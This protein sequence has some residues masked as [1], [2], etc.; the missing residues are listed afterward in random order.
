MTH[1]HGLNWRTRARSR[2]EQAGF[3][4]AE[5]VIA[6]AIS[7]ICLGGVMV[8]NAQQLKL[9]RNTRQAN[10][11]SMALEDRVEQLRL[12]AWANLTDTAW[13]ENHVFDKLPDCAQF[14]PNYTEIVTLTP[15]GETSDARMEVVNKADGGFSVVS[16]GATMAKQRQG[17][18]DVV[19]RW[20]G[21]DKRMRERSYAT[22]ISNGGITRVGL[23][24]SGGS[25]TGSVPG[26]ATS[27]I[28]L[29]PTDN[30]A[31][32]AGAAPSGP[33][34]TP[35]PSPTLTPTEPARAPL[36]PEKKSIEKPGRGNAGGKGGVG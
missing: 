29:A 35:S 11:V 2:L 33:S 1:T 3:T 22:I 5:A 21:A 32:S 15:W 4:L 9:V 14:L 7:A 31:A 34:P 20:E 24:E 17:R 27:A 28:T 18:I 12:T 8:L 16:D 10:A 25:T 26:A 19:V 13:L 23:R 36:E 30:S 6:V